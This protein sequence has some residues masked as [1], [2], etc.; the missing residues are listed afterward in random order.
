[1]RPS[2]NLSGNLRPFEASCEHVALLPPNRFAVQPRIRIPRSR[3]FLNY[4]FWVIG[5]MIERIDKPSWHSMREVRQ[6]RRAT[7]AG[8]ALPQLQCLDPATLP[9]FDAIRSVEAEARFTLGRADVRN[10]KRIIGLKDYLRPVYKTVELSSSNKRLHALFTGDRRPFGDAILT[11]CGISDDAFNR[12]IFTYAFR[13]LRD[14]DYDATFD[15]DGNLELVGLESGLVFLI[16]AD[17]MHLQ[18]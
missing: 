9:D 11:C 18:N 1:V 10:I 16:P 2:R 15:V 4:R 8:L 14:E 5:T 12:T 13:F 7:D 6:F 17:R 3:L